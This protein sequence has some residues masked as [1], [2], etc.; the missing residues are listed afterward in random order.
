MLS[1]ITHLGVDESL[2]MYG[3][4]SDGALILDEVTD[5]IARAAKRDDLLGALGLTPRIVD[6]LGDLLEVV[7]MEASRL[8]VAVARSRVGD[9]T[10]RDDARSVEFTPASTVTFYL[11]LE[12]IAVASDLNELLDRASLCIGAVPVGQFEKVAIG[13][14]EVDARARFVHLHIPVD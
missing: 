6:K 5:R 7:T 13:I 1:A 2:G 14:M 12:A 9:T 11:V 3:Y 4:G 10:I 8:P